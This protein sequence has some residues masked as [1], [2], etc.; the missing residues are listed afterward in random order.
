MGVVYTNSPAGVRFASKIITTT[1]M[2]PL[3][4]MTFWFKIKFG[5]YLGLSEFYTLNP[6]KPRYC[7]VPIQYP[8]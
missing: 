3:F 7:V 1:V 2:I 6:D 8:G 5:L 4:V